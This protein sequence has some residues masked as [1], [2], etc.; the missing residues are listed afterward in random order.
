MNRYSAVVMASAKRD[1]KPTLPAQ[2]L[3]GLPR[4]PCDLVVS[5]VVGLMIYPCNHDDASSLASPKQRLDTF[6]SKCQ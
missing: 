6:T 5:L 1:R 3:G 4:R 2:S